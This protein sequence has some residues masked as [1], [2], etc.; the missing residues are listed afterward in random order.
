MVSPSTYGHG[1]QM[2]NWF[3]A[4]VRCRKVVSLTYLA[5]MLGCTFLIKAENGKPVHG[6]AMAQA[7]TQRRRYKRSSSGMARMRSS[8]SN[9]CGLLTIPPTSTCQG[10]IFRRCAKREMLLTGPNS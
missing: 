1:Y 8:M 6:T 2:R 4:T 9:V 3:S 10:R 7:S 5:R